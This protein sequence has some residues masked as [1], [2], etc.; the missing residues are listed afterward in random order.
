ME[1]LLAA[2]TTME[3]S[4][5]TPT[6]S[7]TTGRSA[8]FGVEYSPEMMNS[9]DR[10]AVRDA[11]IAKPQNRPAPEPIA[12]PVTS[13]IKLLRRCPANSPVLNIRPAVT[14]SFEGGGNNNGL[15]IRSCAR[16]C[17]AARNRTGSHIRLAASFHRL[18][19]SAMARSFAPGLH[20][21]DEAGVDETGNPGW[22]RA[23]TLTDGPI[24]QP[25]NA[26][27]VDGA[28][29]YRAR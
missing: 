9:S 11:P 25:L 5:P 20:G 10:R 19:A 1:K 21:L 13:R 7:I 29:Q 16:I 3:A 12:T 28:V 14:S 6:S 27:E 17:Q 2:I 23:E 24:H 18:C 26:C 8:S 4:S 22:L 15:R